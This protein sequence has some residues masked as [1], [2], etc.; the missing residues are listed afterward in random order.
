VLREHDDFFPVRILRA[1]AELDS[2]LNFLLHVQRPE[3][4]TAAIVSEPRMHGDC[5]FHL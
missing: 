2:A 4:A 3:Y 1:F 5:G